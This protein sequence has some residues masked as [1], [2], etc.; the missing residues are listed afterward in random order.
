MFILLQVSET[1][2][3]SQKICYKQLSR[4]IP[5]YPSIISFCE[6]TYQR[7]TQ[8]TTETRPESQVMKCQDGTVNVTGK[9]ALQAPHI[10]STPGIFRMI[11][12]IYIC[13]Y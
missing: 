2:Q 4:F 12:C 3:F 6:K 10:L 1:L 8:I 11:V 13:I 9:S 7:V 5:W